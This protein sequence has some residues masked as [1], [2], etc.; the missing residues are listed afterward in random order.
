MGA[1]GCRQRMRRVPRSVKLRSE[2]RSSRFRPG[3]D[4][5]SEGSA[6]LREPHIVLASSAAIVLLAE[7]A[8]VERRSAA[9]ILVGALASLAAFFIAWR[10]Q[11]RLRLVPLLLLSLAFQLAWIGLHLHLGVHSVDSSV[12][13]RIWGN[14]LLHGSYPDAQYPPGAVLLFAFDAVVGGGPTRTA[15]AFVM[16]PFQLATVAAV[17]ALRTRWTPWFAALVALWPMNAFSWEFRFDLMPTAFLAIGLLLALRG[18][19]GFAGA[20]FGLG[21]AAKWTP[22]LAAALLV[23]WLV[24]GRRWRPAGALTIAFTSVFVFLHLPFL[25]WSPT[26][27]TYAYRYF[28]GQGVTGESLWYLL[29]ALFDRATV[30]I[31]EFWLPATV[32]DWADSAT[33]VVQ[34]LTLA[35]LGIAA[36]RA[37]GSLRAG[38]AVAAMA[39]VFFLLLNRVFSPQYLVLMLVAWCIAG[40]LLVE[41]PREQLMFGVAVM[42]ATTANALVYPYTLQQH[43]LWRVASAFLF[44]VGLGASAWVVWRSSRDAKLPEQSVSPTSAPLVAVDSR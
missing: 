40:A 41:R 26:E 12:L 9:W 7:Y 24:S 19:W 16:V 30:P 18:R 34:A 32:P 27:A 36:W 33:L 22:G 38:I 23:V 13:Y 25:I 14:D 28:N 29:L 31:R 3:S 42:A 35:G 43:G 10:L 21:A 8:A 5:R 17:W 11:D 20:L 2:A 37:R 39:P 1:D 15:H 4:R 44:V 6:L